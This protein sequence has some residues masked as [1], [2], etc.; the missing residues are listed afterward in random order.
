AP[1]RHAGRDRRARSF[2]LHCARR[3]HHRRDFQRQRRCCAGRLSFWETSRAKRG[4]PTA[5]KAVSVLLCV[6]LVSFVVK[7]FRSSSCWRHHL[8]LLPHFNRHQI[9]SHLQGPR[10]G[11]ARAPLQLLRPNRSPPDVRIHRQLGTCPGENFARL[12]RRAVV[13][14]NT[15][16]LR[17]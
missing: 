10:V 3:L 5:A 9:F 1:R 8:H 16:L 17:I 12:L 6:P 7:F 4:S 2:S 14:D 13:R 15:L 11:F